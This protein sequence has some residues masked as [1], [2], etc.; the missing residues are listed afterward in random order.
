MI[1]TSG[2]FTHLVSSEEV[3]GVC[4][5]ST[6]QGKTIEIFYVHKVDMLL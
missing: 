5:L 1:L 2:N 3:P 6:G 4:L